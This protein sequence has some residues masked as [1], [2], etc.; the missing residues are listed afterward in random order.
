VRR[1]LTIVALALTGCSGGATEST[2][3]ETATTA[4]SPTAETP[5]QPAAP[6]ASGPVRISAPACGY[7]G[8]APA[9]AVF[10]DV[11]TDVALHGVAFSFAIADPASHT[12]AGRSREPVTT[13]VS[14]VERGVLDFS[15]QGTTP[16]DGEL[17][18]GAR[19]RLQYYAGIDALPSGIGGPI[20][21]QLRMTTAEGQSFEATCTTEQMWPS[22]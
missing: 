6:S 21:V 13:V 1:A 20:E 4:A 17:A 19:T 2:P 15:T 5:P 22:S 7:G 9:V 3:P 18:A 11:E 8:S 12:V 16:F 14:P 10:V